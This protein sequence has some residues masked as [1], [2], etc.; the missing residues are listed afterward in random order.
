[1]IQEALDFG[2]ILE[3]D[4]TLHC[5]KCGEELVEDVNWYKSSYKHQGRICKS[6]E[7]ARKKEQRE[8]Y[9]RINSDPNK[10]WP[11]EY[12][13]TCSRCKKELNAEK[14][15]NYHFSRFDGY[16]ALCR[17]CRKIETQTVRHKYIA[18]RSSAK[19]R[20][21]DW[22]LNFEDTS[23]LLL[24]DCYYCGKPSQEEVKIHG[25]DRVDNDRGYFMDNV[26]TCCEE[27]N[28]AKHTQ[29][30]EDFIQQARN[31]AQRHPLENILQ[32]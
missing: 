30:Y 22:E 23:G 16:N 20:D 2:D 28:T 25:L 15:F 31:I 5:R 7:C 10:V 18:L 17:G 9:T 14:H 29:T 3:E 4:C 26:V 27:C 13:K 19:A 1:M 24:Q 12:L 21:I 32:A 6:C 11:S 8:G